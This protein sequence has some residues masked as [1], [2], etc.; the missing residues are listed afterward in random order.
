MPIPPKNTKTKKT[1]TFSSRRIFLFS[2]FG[3]RALATDRR[4]QRAFK[5]FSAA[6]PRTR[7]FT[8]RRFIN[9]FYIMVRVYPTFARLRRF[10][11]ESPIARNGLL[12][13]A[14]N[15]GFPPLFRS[16][17]RRKPRVFPWR[18]YCIICLIFSFVD[19]NFLFLRKFFHFQRRV[20]LFVFL[21]RERNFPARDHRCRARRHARAKHLV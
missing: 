19:K 5:P 21:F 15:T 4:L 10:W 16:F 17:F 9:R 13:K 11:R 18:Q 8:I 12:P 14:R 2:G 1:A 3:S 6:V 20:N 7:L